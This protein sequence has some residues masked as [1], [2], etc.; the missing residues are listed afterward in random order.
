MYIELELKNHWSI[1]GDYNNSVHIHSHSDC[2][3]AVAYYPQVYENSGDIIFQWVEDISSS[4]NKNKYK[5][6][7]EDG[8]YVAFP[9][10]LQH[11]VTKNNN[12]NTRISVSANFDIKKSNKKN[13]A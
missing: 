5:L 9:G 4:W 7:P 8:M 12:K 10:Y 6:T 11:Y 13:K 1:V 2:D 3:I